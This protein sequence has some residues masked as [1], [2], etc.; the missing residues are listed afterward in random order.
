MYYKEDY[1]ILV[2]AYF[3]PGFNSHLETHLKWTK[4]SFL[5]A[6]KKD[7]KI[8]KMEPFRVFPDVYKYH[9]KEHRKAEETR[10]LKPRGKKIENKSS[11][12]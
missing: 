5:R 1:Y 7:R 4:I 9:K 11:D 2:G 6:K 3:N 8:P 12:S 10:A